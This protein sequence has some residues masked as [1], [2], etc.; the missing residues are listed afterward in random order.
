MARK[1]AAALAAEAAEA[2]TAARAAALKACKNYMRVDGDDDDETIEALMAAAAEYLANAGIPAPE[3]E[4]AL[5]N[6]ALYSL[7]LHYYDHRDAVGTEAPLPTGLRPVINQL[8][9]IHNI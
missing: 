4:S 8:K 7:T 3:A 6:L 2:E 9:L 1:S 5:Y